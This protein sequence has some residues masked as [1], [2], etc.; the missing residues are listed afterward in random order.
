MTVNNIPYEREFAFIKRVGPEIAAYVAH[1]L[2]NDITYI[3]SPIDEKSEKK[4][5][6]E[7]MNIVIVTTF[8]LNH[9]ERI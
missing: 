7:R 5:T 6:L 2:K 1:G 3:Y 8:P 9:L 4:Q